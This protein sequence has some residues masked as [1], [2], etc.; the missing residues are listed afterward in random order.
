MIV[1][2]DA[3]YVNTDNIVFISTKTRRISFVNDKFLTVDSE[4]SFL[5]FLREIIPI[6]TA[7]EAQG[8]R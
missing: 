4:V 7:T 2:L 8:E 3:Y 5:N 6:Q 1:K